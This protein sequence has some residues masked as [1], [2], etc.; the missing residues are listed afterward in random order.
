MIKLLLPSLFVTTVISV[1]PN[2][3]V[4][5]AGVVFLA[6][7]TFM[8]LINNVIFFDLEYMGYS[9]SYRSLSYYLVILSV[10]I[11]LVIILSRFK[12]IKINEFSSLFSFLIMFLIL[13][14][15]FTFTTN[16]SLLFYFFFE[17]SLIPTL[18]IIIG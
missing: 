10:W 1:T 3:F 5:L 2:K 4:W 12:I 7:A 15:L 8:M 11:R 9:V 14:L 18:I 17:A 6:L 13:V 16:R